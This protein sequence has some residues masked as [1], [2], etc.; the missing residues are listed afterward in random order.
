M[1]PL[2]RRAIA[3][4]IV[5]NPSAQALSVAMIVE[6]GMVKAYSSQGNLLWEYLA[7]GKLLPFITRTWEGTSYICRTNG[8]L[9]A[10]NRTG[11]ELWKV[12]IKTSLSHAVII[13]WDGRIFAPMDNKIACYNDAGRILWTKELNGSIALTP[14]LDKNGGLLVVLDN[15]KLLQ[16]S[17]FGKIK[18]TPLAQTPSLISSL[19]P[20]EDDASIDGVLVIYS[21]GN[22]E[23]IGEKGQFLHLEASPLAVREYDGKTAIALSNGEV[24]LFSNTGEK[25][26]S[27]DSGVS[28]RY[29]GETVL[30]HNERGV[31]LLGMTKAAG[32]DLNGNVKWSI[33]IKNAAVSPSFGD[34]GVL[35]LSGN[36]WILYA[37]RMEDRH[38]PRDGTWRNSAPL[39]R[40]YGLGEL[41]RQK[42]DYYQFN[43]FSL[44][45]QFDIIREKMIK[46][47]L[48]EDEPSFTVFLKEAAA[49]MR[50]SLSIPASKPPV[51]L[52]RRIEA[53]KLLELFGSEELVPFFADIFLGDREPLVKIAA[54]SAI[55]SIGVD[56]EGAAM[57]AFTQAVSGAADERVLSSVAKAVGALCRRAGPPMMRKGVPILVDI[58]AQ[59]DM[60]LAQKQALDELKSLQ[61]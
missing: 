49:S 47:I 20:H 30:L 38:I 33:D 24:L 61:R 52:P 22:V 42:A 45:F 27:S 54:A 19:F 32:F 58:S 29:V 3:G 31:Y 60:P 10:L 39:K 34:E 40:K 43:D 44:G 16:I 46:G 9:I 2:W 14:V 37:Y 26:W 25:I 6:G 53:V 4:V 35:Y 15:G 56:H 5:G 50:N 13:G 59:A 23:V 57:K 1:V 18:E 41:P 12:D 21:D 55:A 17:A 28:G 11:L 36:D 48:G 51:Y 7:N 8:V